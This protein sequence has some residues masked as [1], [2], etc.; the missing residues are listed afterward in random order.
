M[1]GSDHRDRVGQWGFRC[2]GHH[3]IVRERDQGNGEVAANGLGPATELADPAADRSLG[4]AQTGGDLPVS[5]AQGRYLQPGPDYLGRIHP[6]RPDDLRQQNM[7]GLAS[8]T[9]RTPRTYE[10]PG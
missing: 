10:Q 3:R 4:Q 1:G 8:Q 7:R 5:H 2:L 9:A 6:P